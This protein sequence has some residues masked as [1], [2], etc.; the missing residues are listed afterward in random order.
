MSFVLL[1]LVLRHLSHFIK[2]VFLSLA[3]LV[4]MLLSEA[5]RILLNAGYRLDEGKNGPSLARVIKDWIKLFTINISDS[6]NLEI[7]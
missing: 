6:F 2:R 3:L 1:A 5:K 4:D 7:I